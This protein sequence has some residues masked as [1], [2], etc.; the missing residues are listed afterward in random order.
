MSG[1]ASGTVFGAP[2]RR[3]GKEVVEIQE[4]RTEVGEKRLRHILNVE[5][6]LCNLPWCQNV[7]V[8]IAY[9]TRRKCAGKKENEM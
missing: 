1:G 8:L 7:H 2:R 3:R 4:E 5:N 9:Y 6:L